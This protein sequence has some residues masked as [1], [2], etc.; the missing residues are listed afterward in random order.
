MIQTKTTIAVVLIAI[1]TMGVIGTA[2][3]LIQHALA[4][5]GFNDHFDC[6]PACLLTHTSQSTVP[7]TSDGAVNNHYHNTH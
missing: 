3:T 6:D 4:A 7:S 2:A 1:A 5:V